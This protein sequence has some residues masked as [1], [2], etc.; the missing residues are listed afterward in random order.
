M[1][2]RDSASSDP[3]IVRTVLAQAYIVMTCLMVLT[4][5]VFLMNVGVGPLARR[6]LMLMTIGFCFMFFA[7]IVWAILKVTG[8]YMVGS[9]SDALYLSCYLCLAAA[10]R[11][12]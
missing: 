7:D 1:C 11:E 3:N 5:G 9:L 12:H 10:A 6:T 8:T 4:F 2:I